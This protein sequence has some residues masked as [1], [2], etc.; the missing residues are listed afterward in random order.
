M[1]VT[2]SEQCQSRNLDH[3]RYGR[4]PRATDIP[5]QRS[6]EHY[7]HKTNEQD[8]TRHGCRFFTYHRPCEIGLANT[9]DRRSLG[10]E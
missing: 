6:S 7:H 2:E 10:A 8:T 1:T 4:G 3:S 5:C 9:I